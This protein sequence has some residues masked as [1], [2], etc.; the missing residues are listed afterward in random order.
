MTTLSAD[1]PRDYYEGDFMDYPVVASDII[2]KGAAVGDNG[3]GYARPLQAGDPFR[4]FADYRCDNST[5]L[6]GAVSVRT[7]TRG[8]V[9]L[10]ISSLAITDIGKDVYASDDNTFTLT[11]GSNT[12]IGRVI[13]WI[14]TG[15]GVVEFQTTQGVMF[16]F[17]DSTTGTP[18]DE[19]V[20][21]GGTYSRSNLNDNFSSLSAKIN[22]IVRRLGN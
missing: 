5:G 11:T 21:A 4:G 12:R 13:A 22:T 10:P 1:A 17:S 20:D 8:K 16:E 15:Y 18:G 9:K 7:R 19:L 3:S 2:F 6:A 14:S